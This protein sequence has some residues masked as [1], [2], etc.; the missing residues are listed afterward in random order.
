MPWNQSV[1]QIV[2]I[3]DLSMRAPKSFAAVYPQQALNFFKSEQPD[4]GSPLCVKGW[5]AIERGG[6]WSVGPSSLLGFECASDADVVYARLYLRAFAKPGEERKITI[7][8]DDLAGQDHDLPGSPT[9]LDLEIPARWGPDGC[10]LENRITFE[11]DELYS[12]RTISGGNDA[13]LLGVQ[14]IWAQFA[15]DPLTLGEPQGPTPGKQGTLSGDQ[16]LKRARDLVVLPPRF[17]G[18]R[19]FARAARIMGF[20]K[21]WLA[22]MRAS[23]GGRIRVST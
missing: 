17:T 4:L 11:P 10:R 2:S 3:V 23:S 9:V 7:Y 12:P 20:D 19:P 21:L 1:S 14:L 22:C 15:D 6:R 18:K 13:R 8:V 5:S 16:A